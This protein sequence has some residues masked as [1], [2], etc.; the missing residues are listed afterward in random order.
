MFENTQTLQHCPDVGRRLILKKLVGGIID[1]GCVLHG[2]ICDKIQFGWVACKQE[3]YII[4]RVL[5][6]IE[7]GNH[8]HDTFLGLLNVGVKGLLCVLAAYLDTHRGWRLCKVE[9]SVQK[10][11]DVILTG[12]KGNGQSS[13]AI[14]FNTMRK[15]W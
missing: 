4:I 13:A 7:S 9:V 3:Y 8:F 15:C 6:A 14:L 5:L 2:S 1:R 10:H 11:S 12:F